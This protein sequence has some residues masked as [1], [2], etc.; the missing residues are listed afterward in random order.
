MLDYGCLHGGV[1]FGCLAGL[2][3]RP[4]GI[5]GWNKKDGS[6]VCSMRIVAITSRDPNDR[7]RVREARKCLELLQDAFIFRD[8]SNRRARANTAYNLLL[9][10]RLFHDSIPT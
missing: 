8:Q 9:F 5:D 2:I 1:D 4:R 6:I 7:E 3:N 10:A